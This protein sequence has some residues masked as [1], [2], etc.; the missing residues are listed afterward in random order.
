MIWFLSVLSVYL[1]ACTTA[2]ALVALA[3]VRPVHSGDIL[4]AVALPVLFPF[5]LV[6]QLTRKH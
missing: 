1:W 5:F 2:S 6:V 3:A 4:R